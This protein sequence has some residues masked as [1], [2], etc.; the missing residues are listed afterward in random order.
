MFSPLNPMPR[1]LSD[2]FKPQSLRQ[3]TLVFILLPAFCVL[4]A[5]GGVSLL[6]VR[7]VLL[8]QWQ[9][10]AIAKLERSAQMVDFRLLRMKRLLQLFQGEAGKEMNRQV[11]KFLMERIR[12]SEGVVDVKFD[13]YGDGPVSWSVLSGRGMPGGDTAGMMFHRMAR[14]D[15]TTPKYD[16]ELD[17]QTV[18]LVSEFLNEDDEKVGRIEVK[19]AF[20]ELIGN[21]TDAAWWEDYEAFL[22]DD[23]GNILTRKRPVARQELSR[24]LGT[25]GH[26]GELERRTLVELQSREVGVLFGKGVPP[27]RVSGFYRLREAPW[28]MVVLAPGKLILQPI[29]KFR[30]YYLLTGGVGMLLALWLVHR[31]IGG[32][33]EAIKKVS[34]AANE[35]A[36][37]NFGTPLTV[38]GRDEVAELT[39]NFNI[40]T[41]QLKER[42][43]LQKDMSIAREVQQNLL[44]QSSHTSRRL[45]IAG[46]SV[47]CSETGGDYFDLIVDEQDAARVVVVVGDVVGHGIGAALLM[48]T[49]R[50]L[51][52]SRCFSP[53]GP[54]KSVGDVNRL[55][56]RDTARSGNFVTLFYLLV[57]ERAEELT[58]VRAGHDSAIVYDCDGGE[59]SELRGEGLV[60]GVDEGWRYKRNCFAMGETE[61][62]VL[63]GSDGV[64]ETEN[65]MG[66]RF[67]RDRVRQIL[68]DQCA[69]SPETILAAVN[70]AV[71]AFRGETAQNDD[72]T[73][74]VLKIM[75]KENMG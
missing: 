24:G 73:L 15:V 38:V 59:F 22:V 53:G 40:M 65:S 56:C 32:T 42:M 12:S 51:V 31:G 27:E 21:I 17:G 9:Q 44:P 61:R 64:W 74:V 68:R 6:L 19:I 43:E 1:A 4:L 11:S 52:R 47:Y 75:A 5:M 35:L 71:R 14:L 33:T 16:G 2:I 10:T 46:A 7:E 72:I 18:S 29:M 37:G 57:D 54:E 50:A 28:T 39:K 8:G 58:W 69:E 13:W 26:A 49:V 48:A 20:Y 36:G 23:A 66:E 25:F 62:V 41:S 45:A 55:L 60:L 30:L 70:E 63:I 67:G 34:V 3:R